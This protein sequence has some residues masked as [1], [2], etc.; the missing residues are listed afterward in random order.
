MAYKAVLPA[1]DTIPMTQNANTDAARQKAKAL[2][3]WE[4]E[5]GSLGPSVVALDEEDMRILARL[6]A[7][8][9]IERD[10]IPEATQDAVHAMASTLHAERDARRIQDA[11]AGFL[12]ERKDR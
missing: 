9:L 3:R 7:A 6:G 10:A 2:S 8:F 4:G 5:G 1:Y 11:I 12:D